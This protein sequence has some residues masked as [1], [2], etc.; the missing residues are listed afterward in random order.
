MVTLE[1]ICSVLIGAPGCVRSPPLPSLFR[2]GA[3]PA[4]CEGPSEHMRNY[5]LRC[6]VESLLAD[7]LRE[8]TAGDED[9]RGFRT[10]HVVAPIMIGAISSAPQYT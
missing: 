1:T 2:Q 7:R 10:W 4:L 5:Y 6:L 9:R 8:A 3:R